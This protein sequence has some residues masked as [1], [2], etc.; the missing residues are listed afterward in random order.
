MADDNFV[1]FSIDKAVYEQLSSSQQSSV[2]QKAQ[3]L[4]NFIIT[5]IKNRLPKDINEKIKDLKIKIFLS[6]K[7]G[8]DGLFIPQ[9]S[10]EHTI[11]VKLVQLHSNGIEALL[12]HEIFHAIHFHINPDE[13]AWVREGMAQLFEYITTGDL[14]GMNFYAAINNPI[15][16]LLGDYDIEDPNPAQYGHNQLYFFYMYSHCGQDNF[17]WSLAKGDAD[18]GHRGSFLIDHVLDEMKSPAPECATF[19]ESAINF[20]VA[21]LHNQ[22]QFIAG[23]EKNRYFVFP[24]DIAP[25]FK[26]ITTPEDLKKMLESMPVLSSYRMP[27]KD[28]LNLKGDCATC[29]LY[30]ANN[31]FPYAV[32]ENAPKKSSDSDV[33]IVK[34]RRN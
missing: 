1:R 6:D 33:I 34:L 21:K 13:V 19:T 20:E 29:A 27:L 10:G 11:E 12:A 32:S 18:S 31:Q 15:T 22:M 17:L 4:H 2:A 5:K 30:F 8:R 28:F 16:P 25:K 14:N 26:K 24:G 9:D 7:A 23:E 3:E